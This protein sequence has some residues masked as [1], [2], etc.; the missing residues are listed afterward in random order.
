MPGRQI[1]RGPSQGIALRARPPSL[2]IFQ[3]KQRCLGLVAVL[4]VVAGQ[5]PGLVG[6]PMRSPTFQQSRD[7]GSS[8]PPLQGGRLPGYRDL[9]STMPARALSGPV[10]KTWVGVR[11]LH[12]PKR[13]P[14][15][16]GVV[17][18]CSLV[19]G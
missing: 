5:A 19:Q 14:T 11:I 17:R 9:D 7:L 2:S 12:G 4:A 6:R 10:V 1:A 8:W 3:P 16:A 15:P 13:Q 18:R